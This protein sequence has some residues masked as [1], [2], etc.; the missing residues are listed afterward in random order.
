MSSRLDVI[1]DWVN[2]AKRARYNVNDLEV[3][4]DVSSSQLGRYFVKSFG[5]PPQRWLDELRVW[6][7]AQLLS[8]GLQVKEV[9]ARLWFADR[10]HLDHHFQ[11]YLR[12]APLT[13][14]KLAFARM[15][16]SSGIASKTVSATPHLAICQCALLGRLPKRRFAEDSRLLKQQSSGTEVT[17]TP[18]ATLHVSESGLGCPSHWAPF[19]EAQ[20]E[21]ARIRQASKV[22]PPG[23]LS[24]KVDWIQLHSKLYANQKTPLVQRATLPAHGLHGR[25]RHWPELLQHFGCPAVRRLH[26]HRQQIRRY[27]ASHQPIL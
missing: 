22:A 15:K 12:C 17:E 2:E 16:G 6:H 18:S 26:R 13:F 27:Y 20:S 14:H 8:T 9:A 3:L 21:N 25:H 1:T 7:A 11:R 23:S 10:E 4:C 24:L 19:L 5:K